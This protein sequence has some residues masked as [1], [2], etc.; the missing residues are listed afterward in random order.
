MTEIETLRTRLVEKDIF[1]ENIL[2]EMK[3]I[4]EL[5]DGLQNNAEAIGVEFLDLIKS[6]KTYE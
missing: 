6:M 1:I 3:E 2:L 5:F 4:Y